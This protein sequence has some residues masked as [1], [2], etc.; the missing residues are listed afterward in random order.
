MI[1]DEESMG[2]PANYD[3]TGGPD[4]VT[5]RTVDF[6]LSETKIVYIGY[7]L[8]FV[9]GDSGFKAHGRAYISGATPNPFLL[10]GYI[11]NGESI[12]REMFVV[13]P[14]GSYTVYFQGANT[15]S[16]GTWRLSS[17]R[18]ATCNFP[19]KQRNAWESGAVSCP[20]AT[21]TTVLDQNFTVPATRKL[22]VGSIKKYVAIITT[23][24]IGGIR[25]NQPK[26]PGESNT[27]G[28][29]NWKIFI[30]NTQYAWTERKNDTDNPGDVY[31]R[32]G[33]GRRVSVLN[34]N[35]Q[36]NLKIKVY[37]GLGSAYD[38]WVYTDIIL[39]PWFLAD[40][41]YEPVALD[42][43]Q[44]STIYVYAEPLGQNPTKYISIGK[45]RFVS[46]GDATDY[47][48]TVSG[49]G[50]LTLDYT[51]E[52]VEVVNSVLHVKGFGGCISTIGVDIR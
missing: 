28:W 44:G 4:W 29:F 10:A 51:F 36:Y 32:G 12:T 45:A 1:K 37:N 16:A 42:F 8:S 25:A 22:A 40:I 30:D 46:F 9:S 33:Y 7:T 20:P 27:S 5:G 18:V 50:I 13:L 38:C 23:Y 49:T 31:C 41:Y 47:C 39:C 43:P 35:T 17:M 34:P 2:A 19:D 26:N 6:T 14:A 48:K 3:G 21:E 24:L 11:G 15:G 52:V